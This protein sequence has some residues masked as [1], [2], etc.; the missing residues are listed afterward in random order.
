[1]STV[2]NFIELKNVNRIWAIGSI[3]SNLTSLQSIKEHILENTSSIK[4][5]L[6]KLDALAK[7]AIIFVT[8]DL[9]KLQLMVEF[10]SI[11]NETLIRI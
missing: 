8:D 5:A 7:D 4:D 2:S 9:G 11:F 10:Y 6:I 3:H 1:M